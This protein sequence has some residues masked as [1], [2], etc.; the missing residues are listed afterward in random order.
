MKN[1][2]SWKTLHLDHLKFKYAAKAAE[3]TAAEYLHDDRLVFVNVYRLMIEA[4]ESLPDEPNNYI[5]VAMNAKM[6]KD[7]QMLDEI[8]DVFRDR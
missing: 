7:R 5:C 1:T 2:K 3:W 8:L 4:L 6:E